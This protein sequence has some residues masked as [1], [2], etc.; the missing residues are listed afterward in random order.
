MEIITYADLLKNTE[1]GS[2]RMGEQLIKSEERPEK[3]DFFEYGDARIIITEHFKKEG[4]SLENIIE[5][6][7]LR[8]ARA[9]NRFSVLPQSKAG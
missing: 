2:D 4:K 7:V 9:D 8:Q 1:G 6:S 3:R 5:E